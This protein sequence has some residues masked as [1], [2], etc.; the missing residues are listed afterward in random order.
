[1]RGPNQSSGE[2]G[3]HLENMLLGFEGT[4]NLIFELP[5]PPSLVCRARL[6]WGTQ[7]IR[8]PRI[9][10]Q[11]TWGSLGPFFLTS[12]LSKN[13]PLPLS[14]GFL[15]RRIPGKIGEG[16]PRTVALSL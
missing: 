3:Q 2:L 7:P 13:Q 16:T 15:E 9:E 11:L 6:A 12:V 4:E 14:G 5:S 10:V 1:M 8:T